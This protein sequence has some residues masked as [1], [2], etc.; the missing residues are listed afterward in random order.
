MLARRILA[1]CFV[2]LCC[3]SRAWAAPPIAM[4]HVSWTARD[5]APQMVLTMAQTRDGWL[6]LGSS[7]GLFRFDGVRFERY[8][9][10]GQAL[11]S[12]GIGILNAFDDGAL[13][14]GYRYGGASVLA[15]G[16]L[17]HYTD[18]DGLPAGATVWG[19]E[20]DGGGRMWAATKQ[21]MFYLDGQ[22]W[23]AAGAAFGL[24]EGAYKTLMR[25]RAGA[26]WAQGA[27]GVYRLPAG[28]QRFIKATP[29]SGTGVLFQVPDGSVWS[30]NAVASRLSRLT[31]PD[32][33][34]APRRW[35]TDGEE[36]NSLLFD[37]QGDLWVGRIN[38]VEHHGA[39]AVQ[40]SG[41]PQGLSGRWVACI[42]ED[43]EGSIWTSTS[44]GIDRFRRQRLETVDMPVSTV[45]NPLAPDADGGMWVGRYHF[46]RPHNGKLTPRVLDLGPSMALD[47]DLIVAYR[48]TAGVLWLGENDR[49]FRSSGAGPVRAV[50]LPVKDSMVASMADD[51]DGALWAALVPQGLYRLDAQQ[52][53]HAMQAATGLPDQTPHVVASSPQLGLWL[54]YPRG[55]VLQLRQGGWRRYGPGEGLALNKLEAMHVSR[56][57]VW[58][59]GEKG[60]ALWLGERFVPV[61]GVGG[62]ELEGVSGIV[63]LDNGD[64][65]VDAAAGLFRIAAAEIARLK[66]TAGYR[67]RYEKLDSLD[68]LTG[69]APVR[70]PVPTLVK[71]TDN[72][73]WLSTTSGVFRMD[74][75]APPTPGPAAPVLIR[76]IGPPGQPRPAL[77][78]LRLAA[79]TTALQIDYTA[80]ALAMPER[81]AFRYR[82]EGVDAQW[83]EVGQR[84]EAYY[85]N[86]GP[87]DYRFSVDVT[88]YAG[89]WSERPATL[90]FSIAPTIAQSWWFKTLCALLLLVACWMLY[91]RRMRVV[92]LQ[93]AARLEGRT[94]ERERIA[95]ELHDTLLQSVQGMILHVQAATMSLPEPEP[96]R[97]KIEAAL[98]QADDALLEGRER[99]RD[100]RAGEPGEQ[101]LPEAIGAVTRRF[102]WTG[103]LQ[104]KVEGKVRP[105]H[106]LIYEELLAIAGEAVANA[107][108]HAGAQRIDVGLRYGAAELRLTVRDD[109]A[110]IPAEVM[111]A[112]GRSNH[113]GICGMYERAER[114]KA[115]LTLRS[116]PGGGTEWLLALPGALAYQTPPRRFWFRRKS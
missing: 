55:P 91:R 99:V 66:S 101:N 69:N 15:H 48:D 60:M 50:P 58:V 25:D 46:A 86:L 24:P 84:R 38:G 90:A 20:R 36:V 74:P 116:D 88:D 96:A 44:T 87:G 65:W 45:T 93:V 80:L 59:G 2:F 43:R 57:H 114:I 18:R 13:W 4:H 9:P 30:W 71:T 75:S 67:V 16:R 1:F 23:V 95:R 31:R 27:A 92:A 68:G 40:R 32:D 53:W 41:L 62:V 5:G 8:A 102:G 63:E 12:V 3:T 61:G 52:R 78:G 113:W 28:G 21:G 56:S 89:T 112:G 105:L 14:I 51:A 82:L 35:S 54:A 19:L 110:G 10:P 42:F 6:W 85:N 103:A 107:C 33:G 34:A 39:H 100:L 26:L 49:L 104:A 109:G 22:R 108:R 94:R 76:A 37:R 79:G 73:L 111:A 47:R 17:R 72:K 11:P 106:P 98:Q 70:Y 64:L 81:V 77:D 115:R 29:D 7:T 97:M 83:Q